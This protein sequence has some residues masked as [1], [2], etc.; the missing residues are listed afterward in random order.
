MTTVLFDFDRTLTTKDTLVPLAQYLAETDRRRYKLVWLYIFLL[1]YRLKIINDKRLKQKFLMLFLK[2][3]GQEHIQIIIKRFVTDKL[4]S[5]FKQTAVNKLKEHLSSG[6]QIYLVSANFD[7]FLEH[8]IER[9]KLFGLICTK[10]E[11]L[12][13]NFTG[14]I[15]GCTCK[16]ENKIKEIIERFGTSALKNIVAYGDN[17]DDYLLKSVGRGINLDKQ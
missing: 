16:G 9:W 1:F 5:M 6:D 8:L 3:K 2:N 14:K 7:F 10:T 11:K 12:N 17:E 4:E 13:S 15:I